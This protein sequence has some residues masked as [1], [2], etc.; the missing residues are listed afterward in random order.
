AFVIH[1]V[2]LIP[3]RRDWAFPSRENVDAL[4]RHLAEEARQAG[5]GAPARGAPERTRERA[6]EVHFA[7]HYTSGLLGSSNAPLLTVDEAGGITD[8]SEALCQ[9]LQR[10]RSALLTRPLS[11]FFVNPERLSASLQ[12]CFS[13]GKAT[14]SPQRLHLPD[15]SAVPVLVDGL[16]YRDRG[17]LL[18]AAAGLRARL[19][20]REWQRLFSSLEAEVRLTTARLTDQADEELGA[21][22]RMLARLQ[23]ACPVLALELAASLRTHAEARLSQLLQQAQALGLAPGATEVIE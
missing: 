1:E 6:G 8:A 15:G 4:M 9:L 11:A 7:H 5:G 17:D 21:S 10:E 13:Q 14:A 23:G 19:P 20:A 22:N 3:G 12:R 16:V 18:Q 2:L